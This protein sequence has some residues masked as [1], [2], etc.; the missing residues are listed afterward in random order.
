M[1][2]AAVILG[3]FTAA[4]GKNLR[5]VGAAL[6]FSSSPQDPLEIWSCCQWRGESFL[7][8]RCNLTQLAG[9]E[10]LPEGAQCADFVESLAA[11]KK[12]S[13]VFLPGGMLG[14]EVAARLA[15]RTGGSVFTDVTAVRQVSPEA[16]TVE[17]EIYGYNLNGCFTSS[18]WPVFITL[19]DGFAEKEFAPGTVE[20]KTVFPLPP[21]RGAQRNSSQLKRQDTGLAQAKALMVC[22]RGVSKE[23]VQLLQEFCRRTGCALGA[24]KAAIMDGKMPESAM[25]GISGARAKPEVTAVFGASGAAAFM[26]GVSESKLLA[27]VNKD[28]DAL[29]FHYCDVGMEQDSQAVL[30][31]LHRMAIKP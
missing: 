28:P 20:E 9:A 18:R 29:I 15:A 22:G 13:L 7:L 27:A 3:D 26:K 31:E 16:V 23:G 25:V 24:T 1:K 19:S 12:V 14:N 6:S 10:M 11:A 30:E 8:P 17:R 2:T 21:S 5:A 4:K